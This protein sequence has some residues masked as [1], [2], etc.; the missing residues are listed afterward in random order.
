MDR[1]KLFIMSLLL[2]IILSPVQAP[3]KNLVFGIEGGYFTPGN[4]LFKDIYGSGGL[5][6]G[7]NGAFFLTQNL[8]AQ[9]GFDMYSADGTIP[10]TDNATSLK[11]SSL[12]LGVFYHFDMKKFMPK[13][14]AGAVY[15]GVKETNVFGDFSDSGIGF[16]VGTGFDYR[17]TEVFLVGA[18]LIYHGAKIE[19]DF[20]DESV[21]GISLLFSL[22]VEM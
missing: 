7:V 22:K 18:D 17:L 12:R 9:A 14:G 8:S 6:Y 4:S 15:A 21:G 16:F 19:G 20:G 11:L 2:T 10:G 3:A 1:K 13:I 5:C